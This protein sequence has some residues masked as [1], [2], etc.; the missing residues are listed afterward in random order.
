MKKILFLI[1][2]LAALPALAQDCRWGVDH[3]HPSCYG[4]YQVQHRYHHG[5]PVIVQRNSDWVGP[6]I[7]TV[8]G[9]AVIADIITRN[10]NETVVVQQPPVIQQTQQCSP[11]IETQ[12][13]DGSITRTRTCNQ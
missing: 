9:G 2:M 12:N 13:P 6:A 8:I 3:K 7:V 1:G 5:R 11:W 4:Y 10:R